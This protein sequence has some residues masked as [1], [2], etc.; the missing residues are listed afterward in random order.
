[1]KKYGIF[2]LL[3][4]IIGGIGVFSIGHT[5]GVQEVPKPKQAPS[6]MNTVISRIMPVKPYASTFTRNTLDATN[7]S[8][9]QKYSELIKMRENTN[10]AIRNIEKQIFNVFKDTAKSELKEV[11]SAM[12]FG[13]SRTQSLATP[14]KVALGTLKPRGLFFNPV[15]KINAFKQSFELGGEKDLGQDYTAKATFNSNHLLLKGVLSKK[16]NQDFSLNFQTYQQL[17]NEK[18]KAIQFGINFNF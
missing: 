8:I 16:I 2:I 5:K 13:T 18:N 15:L 6:L 17:S 10:G 14:N 12:I 11:F 9:S 3:L 7:Q 4:L 1:M